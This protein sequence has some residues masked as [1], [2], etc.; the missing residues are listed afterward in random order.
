VTLS[1]LSALR[2]LRNP[3][4]ILLLALGLSGLGCG[5][6]K[7][8]RTVPGPTLEVGKPV[9]RE[10][11]GAETHSYRLPLEE[12]TYIR[13][14]IDQPGVDVTAKLIDPAG[15]EVGFFDDPKHLDEPDRLVWISETEG[16]HQLVV[17]A[18]DRKGARG[19]YRLKLEEERSSTRKDSER[20]AA[21]KAYQQARLLLVD[22]KEEAKARS[23]ELQKRALH[24]W[25]AAG[26][27]L[28]QV[29]SLVQI[30]EIQNALSKFTDALAA[31]EKARDLAREVGYAEGDAR[32]WSSIGDAYG[33]LGPLERGLAS[34]DQALSRWRAL[35]EP[36]WQG[37]ILYS[38]GY[39]CT[40]AGR[41]N[42]ALKYLEQ[43]QPLLDQARNLELESAVLTSLGTI[44]KD[45]GEYGKALDR[46]ESSLKLSDPSLPTTN[47]AATLILL[48]IIHRQRGELEKAL[49]RFGEALDIDLRLGD[50][51][52]EAFAR[53]GLGSIYFN[54]GDTDRALKE[55]ARAADL[56]EQQPARKARLLV[57]T[58]LVYHQGK[59]EPQVALR[60]YEQA[61]KLFASD[62]SSSAEALAYN[63]VGMAYT[64]LGRAKEGLPYLQ[65]ALDLRE[66]NGER[67]GQASTLMEIGTT[68]QA[69]GDLRRTAEYY[70]KAFQLASDLGSTDLQAESLH[71][72]ALL[73][74]RR[75]DLSAA[76]KRI[77]DSLRIVESVRS[78]VVSDK[79]R[80]SF[81]ASK[82]PYYE[83]LVSLLAELESR[84]PGRFKAEALEASE[85]ARARSLLDL[86]AEGNVRAGISPE[87]RKRDIELRSRLSWLQSELDK[88]ASTELEAEMDRVQDAMEQLEREIRQSNKPY[89]ELRYPKPLRADQIG[90]LI[91]ERSVLLQ[92]FT[93]EDASFLFVVT[94][95][96]LEIHRLP[97]SSV[98]TGKVDQLRRLIQARG[99]RSLPAY[100]Q[101][102]A[103]LYELLVG[104]AAPALA[105]KSHLLIAPDGP[106]YFL[107]FEALVT[108]RDGSSYSEIP[109]L[110]KKY[111]IS[112]VP[113]AS[114]LADLQDRPAAPS[115]KR[116]L[117]FADP[118]YGGGSV[119]VTRS[120][121]SGGALR[122]LPES[123][124]EVKRIADLFPGRETAIYLGDNAT[125]QNVKENPYLAV[126]SNVHFALHGTVNED[127]PELSGLELTRVSPEDGRL[128]VFEI[129]DLK[130]N[131]DLLTLSACQ[132]A[133]GK[134]VRGEGVVGLTRAF[135][136]AGA[137]SLV[138]SLW[139]VPDRSTSD[140]MYDMYRNLGSGKAEAL[141]RAKLGMISSERFS[142]P[143]YWA[144][145]ILS[146]DPR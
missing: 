64:V 38:K 7:P 59:R 62:P 95:N 72:W 144:P 81:F 69:L 127:R 55:Y 139:P 115:E 50:E 11:G 6:K 86:L 21:A 28:G 25:Q 84:N 130:L 137:R 52:S 3:G 47:R 107:P 71:R 13:L 49:R 136:Y 121:G 46:V 80:T 17:Q 1:S 36:S 56:F 26:D 108:G 87:L 89:A 129:F 42:E 133:L 44:F 126:A 99:R 65:K 77:Q 90:S 5:E 146:G 23:L 70:Q 143:Y 97:G 142:E 33:R 82:R 135:L 105:G 122:Q 15:K 24:H 54:L 91:D 94:R 37:T 18:Q 141:R 93:G 10:I 58:G 103:D 92:Y 57:N 45:Q 96:G 53:Q 20:L 14:R 16:D 27:N 32:A 79:L 100:E 51:S 116:F 83:L 2:P 60:F 78:Q 35:G 113:S 74:R 29:D 39:I 8:E 117:A 134:E 66:K 76:L 132:T 22:Q 48:G 88:R 114:V 31:A 30:A 109:Y 41:Q 85:R 4:V 73:D 40:L 63:N 112:Y 125:E 123:G 101:S 140:L 138:V 104:P 131:A 75:G 106:L 102:A 43:A 120:S 12:D 34:F 67:G 61:L 145:F 9:R 68:Y 128:Q 119:G 124:R 110:L 98:L 118:D 19:A 111:S